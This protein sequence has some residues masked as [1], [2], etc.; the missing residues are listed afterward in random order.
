MFG[1]QRC[2]DCD[3]PHDR[4]CQRDGQR[5]AGPVALHRYAASHGDQQW[6]GS[7][8]VELENA[9]AGVGVVSPA[10]QQARENSDDDHGQPADAGR[11]VIGAA[12]RCRSQAECGGDDRQRGPHSDDAVGQEVGGENHYARKALPKVSES[13]APPTAA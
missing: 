12:R 5:A 7:E 10:G 6:C 13:A 2:R 4:A 11:A 9:H 1:G 3:A 8:Q